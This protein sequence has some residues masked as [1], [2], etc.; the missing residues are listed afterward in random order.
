MTSKPLSLAVL[1]VLLLAAPASGQ[2]GVMPGIGPDSE[3]VVAGADFAAGS[4]HRTMLGDNYRDDWVTP[5]RL[6]VLHLSTFGG[7]L[8]PVK[9]GGGNQTKS[10]RFIN[11]DSLEYVFRPIHKEGVNLPDD[12]KGTFVWWIF[13]DAG[14]ASHPAATAA[15]VPLMEIAR[16][17]HPSPVLVVMGDDA[18]L[19]EF[20][21]Q[22]AGAVGTIELYPSVPKRGEAFARAVEIIDAEELLKRLNKSPET[23]VDANSLLRARMVDMLLGDNDRH[24][25]QWKWARLTK[26]GP[27]EPIARDRDKVFISYEGLVPALARRAVPAL[28]AYGSKYS[29]ATALF[30]NAVEFDRRLLGGLDKSVWE[31]TARSIQAAA[32]DDVIQ[33]TI[34]IMPRAYASRSS[35]LAGVLRARRDGLV[36][37][38]LSYYAQLFTFPD[39]HATDAADRAAVIRRADG[40]VD[41]TLQANG[42]AP[43]FQRHYSPEDTREIRIYLHEGDDTAAV[44]G[45]APESIKLR[46][47]G[48][49]GHNTLIDESVV[50]GDRDESVFYDQGAV[51]S[52]RY[53]R[54]TA[55]ERSGAVD[56]LNHYHNRRPAVHAYGHLTLPEKDH[57]SSIQPVVGIKTG[58]GLGL[59][60]KVGVVRYAY[61]FRKV[62]YANMLQADLAYATGTGG[63]RANVIGDQRYESSDFHLTAIATLSQLEVIQFRGFGNRV[64]DDDRPFYDVRQTQWQ[65]R[66]AVG[67]SFAPGSDFTIGPIIRYTTTDSATNRFISQSRPYGFDPF[68][69][70]GIKAMLHYET[71]TTPDSSR[72]RAII[73][74]AGSGYPGLWDAGT[75]YQS[76]EG[77]ATTFTT[78]PLPNKPVVALRGGGKKLFGSFPY[79]DAAFIGGGGSLRTEHRQRYAGNASL[80]GSGELRVPLSTFKFIVPLDL[81]TLGF[82]DA[83]RVYADGE[84]AAGWHSAAGIGF[85]LGAVNASKNVNVLL[86][87]QSNRRIMVNLG[88]AY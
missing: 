64:P 72:P 53:L 23:R 75:A 69:E 39:V 41:V 37:A 38:A 71:R 54:D 43:W 17:L 61:G 79:F 85:W 74:V 8:T 68:A 81:G 7:G 14:S 60:P 42:E 24:A 67:L 15:S 63:Y 30:E 26:E 87:N 82:Y 84:T 56:A 4:F 21:S 80:F 12:F 33:R 6:P 3:T 73:E 19:G 50:G 11:D 13:K 5:V 25:D 48:G 10:L 9:I 28:V 20:R 34:A 40:S 62:P 83:A 49:N 77:V 18:R 22:Y 86:T 16:V 31:A 76:I 44:T 51:T 66:P 1:S 55:L 32:T 70:A 78:L 65:A 46:I 27:F 35:E 88:F 58:H 59:V 2:S 29:D 47:I 36:D 45:T 57:G 52:V